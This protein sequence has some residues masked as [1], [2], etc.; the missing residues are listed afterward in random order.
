MGPYFSKSILV[1][2]VRVSSSN[3]RATQP[4][5]HINGFKG[6]KLVTL[7]SHSLLSMSRSLLPVADPARHQFCLSVVDLCLS[8]IDLCSSSSIFAL[9]SQRPNSSSPPSLRYRR[10]ISSLRFVYLWICGSVLWVFV[11][12]I[13]GSVLWVCRSSLWVIDLLILF[14]RNQT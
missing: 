13:C 4:D 5:R 8:I 3:T 1:D 6:L 11:L 10:S 14:F 2:R 9:R 12:W 7:S